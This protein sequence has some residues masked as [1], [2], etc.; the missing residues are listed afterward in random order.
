MPSRLLLWPLALVVVVILSACNGDGARAD[1]RLAVAAAGLPAQTR[2]GVQP[3]NQCNAQAAQFV[4]GQSYASTMLVQA[5]A[6]AGAG[7][8]RMLRVNDLITQEYILGRLNLVVDSHRQ[9]VRVYCG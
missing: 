8:V 3:R 4:V 5:R 2:S 1:D 6:A 9:V 7:E